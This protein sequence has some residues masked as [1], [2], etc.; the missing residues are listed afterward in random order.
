[1]ISFLNAL[2]LFPAFVCANH[3]KSLINRLF[4]IK[5]FN[6]FS[7]FN[8]SSPSGGGTSSTFYSVNDQSQSWSLSFKCIG[9]IFDRSC[10]F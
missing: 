3:I 2:E 10:L 8:S 4:G 5:I 1:M 7:S 9:L 6:H